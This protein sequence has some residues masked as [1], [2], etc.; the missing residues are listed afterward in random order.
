MV[1][2]FRQ[3]FRQA[4][5]LYLQLLVLSG[6]LGI[7]FV[8]WIATSI[9]LHRL[10]LFYSD[11]RHL[12]AVSPEI[13]TLGFAGFFAFPIAVQSLG[14]SKAHAQCPVLL[15]PGYTLREGLGSQAL[16]EAV[17][18]KR[19]LR[20]QLRRAWTSFKMGAISCFSFVGPVGLKNLRKQLKMAGRL[21]RAERARRFQGIPGVGADRAVS[22]RSRDRAQVRPEWGLAGCSAFVVAPRHRTAGLNLNGRSFLHSYNWQNDTEFGVLELIMTAPMVVASWI[23]LQYYA[24]TVDNRVFGSGNKTLHNVVGRIGVLEGNGGDLRVGL[25]WQSVHDGKDYQHPPQRLQVVIEAPMDAVNRILEKHESVRNLC[26]NGWLFLSLMDGEGRIA[27]RYA[28]NL[29]WR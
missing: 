9:S 21:S 26:D 27:H 15:S 4:P 28:G 17:V 18:Q 2:Q 5:G 7:F 16:D 8:A 29:T 25:P 24:S 23:S 1:L 14:H 11:R 10:L 3:E 19:S 22:A 20:G 13:D 6:N 12:E